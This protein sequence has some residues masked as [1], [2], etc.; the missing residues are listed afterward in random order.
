M[1][2]RRSVLLSL[3]TVRYVIDL[4]YW[5]FAYAQHFPLFARTRDDCGVEEDGWNA[6]GG[7]RGCD[8]C[9]RTVQDWSLRDWCWRHEKNWMRNG[10]S[11]IARLHLLLLA[12][13][14][15]A[16]YKMRMQ[17]R[18]VVNNGGATPLIYIT[19]CRLVPSRS[20]YT[21]ELP[22]VLSRFSLHQGSITP[23]VEFSPSKES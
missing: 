19:V 10:Y 12:A 8:L 21:F 7:T 18:S 17:E 5:T 23:K 22:S 1:Q 2:S 11:S 6:A 16:R 13:R 20:C 4:P 9:P 15:L 14:A 3:H